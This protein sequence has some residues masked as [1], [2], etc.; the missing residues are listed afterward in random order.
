M[1]IEG[2]ALA[3]AWSLEQTRFFTMGCD[4]LLVVVDHKPLVKILG[5]RGLD[6][7]DSPRLFRLKL[8]TQMWK[9]SVEYQP[10]VHNHFAD[11]VS[12]HPTKSPEVEVTNEELI[13][14]SI[15]TDVQQFTAVTW[16]MVSLESKKDLVICSLAQYVREGFPLR[17]GDL[18]PEISEFWEYRHGL[19]LSESVVLYKDRIVVPA[20]LRSKVLENL[21]SAHK[22]VPGDVSTHATLTP[23]RRQECLQRS[24]NFLK[25]LL[26]KYALIFSN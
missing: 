23:L 26:R 14:S 3:V 2:E 21:H 5:D 10:G 6:E 18:P 16:E 9:F 19:T 13:V 4:N 20:A 1:A 8:R 12:T 15:A 17:K 25:L 24:Q 7:I 11:A 22:G